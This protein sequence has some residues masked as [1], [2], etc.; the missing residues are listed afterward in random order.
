M[1]LLS[2][3]LAAILL[4]SAVFREGKRRCKAFEKAGLDVIHAKT[5]NYNGHI[6][7]NLKLTHLQIRGEMFVHKKTTNV[8][9]ISFRTVI[10]LLRP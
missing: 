2:A 7:A 1:R 9:I 4:R 10:V 6:W 3:L 8:P 5:H